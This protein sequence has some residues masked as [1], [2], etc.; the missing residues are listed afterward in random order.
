MCKIITKGNGTAN[1]CSNIT[2]VGFLN[3]LDG[4]KLFK[5]QNENSLRNRKATHIHLED[6]RLI[7]ES[8]FA[9]LAG[10]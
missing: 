7:V 4:D 5:K 3:E 2:K 10:A 1:I 9:M 8:R 6:C